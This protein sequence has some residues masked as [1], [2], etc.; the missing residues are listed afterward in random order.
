MKSF[1]FSQAIAWL[2]RGIVLTGPS[3][4]ME[5]TVEQKDQHKTVYCTVCSKYMSSANFKRHMRK[6]RDNY[7]LDK[8]NI[9]EKR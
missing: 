1:F 5:P 3:I 8:N 9:K 4:C 2:P 7:S 6:H